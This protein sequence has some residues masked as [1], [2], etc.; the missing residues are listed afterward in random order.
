[1][2]Q[3][4][5]E[6]FIRTPVNLW[7]APLSQDVLNDLGIEKLGEVLADE[8]KSLLGGVVH[9]ES[10]NSKC[11]D[12][13][14]PNLEI[15]GQMG[16]WDVIQVPLA[17]AVVPDSPEKESNCSAGSGRW[18]PTSL[19]QPNWKLGSFCGE[20]PQALPADGAQ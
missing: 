15:E 12:G 6:G 5:G 2:L 1:M 10:V 13:G 11:L 14:C 16:R 4:V 3:V 9:G 17:A 8:G 19:G 18:D 7:V 20:G